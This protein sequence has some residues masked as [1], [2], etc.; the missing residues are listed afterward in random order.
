MGYADDII[1]VI[2]AQTVDQLQY[3]L[4]QA[5][6][7]V[8]SWMEDHMLKLAI[9]KTEIVLLTTKRIERCIPMHVEDQLITTSKSIRYLGIMLDKLTV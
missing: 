4:N 6:R 3:K 7:R 9:H 5:M 8:T 2:T 1:L